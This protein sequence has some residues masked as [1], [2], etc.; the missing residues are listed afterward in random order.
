MT[1]KMVWPLRKPRMVGPNYA[2]STG[3]LAVAGS[4]CY[5]VPRNLGIHSGFDM[6]GPG[7]DFLT[8]IQ[9]T[10]AG[11]VLFAGFLSVWGNVVIIYHP[12]LKL[13]TRSAHLERIDVKPGQVLTTGQQIGLMGGGP[14]VSSG[15]F[16]QHTGIRTLYPAHLHFDVLEQIPALWG[17]WNGVAYDWNNPARSN[18]IALA[19]VKRVY[20]APKAYFALGG[21]TNIVHEGGCPL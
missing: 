2:V 16:L 7:D 12:D 15:G 18:A 8:P 11:K 1:L 17:Y 5:Q 21:I 14:H 20:R 6:N 9:A 4:N 19:N 13:V 10:L 3:F